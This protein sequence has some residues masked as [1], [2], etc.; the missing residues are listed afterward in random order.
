[1]YLKNCNNNE[2]LRQQLAKWLIVAKS[3]AA[4]KK[5]KRK[6]KLSVNFRNKNNIFL[7]CALCIS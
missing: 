7:M 3:D 6:N 1:M 2:N 5:E 4:V